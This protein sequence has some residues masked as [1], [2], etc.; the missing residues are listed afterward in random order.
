MSLLR[1]SDVCWC[2]LFVLLQGAAAFQREQAEMNLSQ[3]SA[4]HSTG[5]GTSDPFKQARGP[6]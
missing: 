5:A 2:F 6:Y 4:T 3:R 1:V